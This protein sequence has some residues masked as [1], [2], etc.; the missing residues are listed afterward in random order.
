MS[1]PI[2]LNN[3]KDPNDALKEL[4]NEYVKTYGEE[5]KI[6]ELKVWAHLSERFIGFHLEYPVLME[7]PIWNERCDFIVLGRNRALIIEAKGWNNIERLENET[8]KGDHELHIEPGYQ[9]LN[10]VSKFNYFHSSGLEIHYKGIL[11]MY[12]NNTYESDICKNNPDLCTIVHNDDELLREI[13]SLGEPGGQKEIKDVING[14][15]VIRHDLIDLINKNKHD[16]LNQATLTFLKSGYGLN[17]EQAK[18]INKIMNSLRNGEDKTYLI[19][20]ESGSGKTLVA[21]RLLLEAIT[22]NY[23]AILA[24]RN[25]RLLNT[26]RQILRI[27]NDRINISSLLLYYSTGKGNGIG[28]PKF[29]A[30]NYGN[31]DLIIYDEAQ[32]MTIDVINTTKYRSRVKVYFYDDSQILIGDEEGTRE[33]FRKYLVNPEE[34]RLTAS[35]RLNKGYL[36]FVRQLLWDETL[37]VNDINYDIRMYSDINDMLLDLRKKMEQKN[38]DDLDEKNKVALL[39]SFTESEGDKTDLLK[40]RRL[41]YPLQSGFDLYKGKDIDIYWLMDEKTEYPKYWQGELNSLNYC[42]SV[43]GAQGFEADYVGLVWGRDL[44]WRG[45]WKVNP[46]PITDKVGNNYSLK[47]LA[48]NSPAKALALLKNRYYIL[49]TRGISGIDIFFEDKETEKHV[50]DLLDQL[51]KK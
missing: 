15:F 21:L 6:E 44:I 30:H 18:I 35:F 39:C 36:K 28:E 38:K 25:N 34:L 24:Y 12:N 37:T 46:G 51:I 27:E 4:K 26:M 2:I 41:G 11:F 31:I 29:P 17:E 13:S 20:G 40:K 43:Y 9:V 49:L 32:R 5:P 8:V 22:N 23:N 47:R 42:A 48:K 14:R 19:R 3:F 7:V 50:K 16:L 33:N 45:E 10:Y 1:L